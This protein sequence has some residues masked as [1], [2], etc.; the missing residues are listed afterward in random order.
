M[1]SKLCELRGTT[2]GIARAA[3]TIVQTK[4]KRLIRAAPFY[5]ALRRCNSPRLVAAFPF[6]ALDNSEDPRN[7]Q[8]AAEKHARLYRS[9]SH[10][11]IPEI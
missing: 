1:N 5:L 11:F 10:K 6:L 8:Y 2:G 7:G 9:G 4:Q 3:S